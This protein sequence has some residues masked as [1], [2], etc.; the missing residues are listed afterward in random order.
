MQKSHLLIGLGGLMFA[1]SVFSGSY[2]AV[3]NASDNAFNK[4]FFGAYGISQAN[5][6][7]SILLNSTSGLTN[8]YKSDSYNA[9][10]YLL[11]F[12]VSKHYK[13]LSNGMKVYIGAEL[14]YLQ[15]DNLGGNIRPAT[16]LAPNIDP[17]RYHFRLDS[18]AVL[19]NA[20]IVKENVFKSWG[21]YLKLGL[22]GSYNHLSNYHETIVPGSGTSPMLAPFAS[23][24]NFDVAFSA[25][26]GVSKEL[27]KGKIEVGYRYLNNGRGRLGTTPVQTT[28]QTIKTGMI[29]SH[30]VEVR[31]VV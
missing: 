23:N 21:G 4:E 10:S 24:N 17:L 14:S 15:N 12:G 31:F 7:Q 18:A 5:H 27:K 13:T 29:G 25:G 6:N 9:G 11:G 16:N 30:M 28:S 19:V 3:D 22:G 8:H 1:A 26:F 2:I 20:K